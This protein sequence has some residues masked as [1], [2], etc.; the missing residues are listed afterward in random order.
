[1]R[2]PHQGSTYPAPSAEDFELYPMWQSGRRQ[3]SPRVHVVLGSA[4]NTL[5]GL[6]RLA[7]VAPEFPSPREVC[8]GCLR[9]GHHGIDVHAVLA[10]VMNYFYLS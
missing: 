10:K 1:M 9:G 2:Q 8:R 7:D 4:S 3:I 5:C 6:Y